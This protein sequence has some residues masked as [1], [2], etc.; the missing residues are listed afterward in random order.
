M[1]VVLSYLSENW[2]YLE[3]NR[4][5]QRNKL[6]SIVLTPRFRAS[7]HLIF[8][9]LSEKQRD[10]ILVA[11][12]PRI[13]GDNTR[14]LCEAEN[15]RQ[16]Q[17]MREGGFSSIPRLIA[18]D[19]WGG[20]RLLI[21]TALPGQP[22]KPAIVRE[23]RTDCINA[24]LSWLLKVQV[25]S[26]LSSREEP[27]WYT[28]LVEQPIK[29]LAS[30]FDV[31]SSEYQL[32]GNLRE[33]IHPLQHTE[34]PLVFEHGDLSSPNI[35][36]GRNSEI[37]VVDWELSDPRGYPS[38]DL[39]FFL[40]YVAFATTKARS[41]KDYVTAFDEAFF[42][43]EAWAV[44]YLYEYADA[45]NLP[46]EAIKPLFLLYWCRNLAKL[47][48]RLEYGDDRKSGLSS[49]TN[50]WLASNRFFALWKHAM[51]NSDKMVIGS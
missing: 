44:P 47:A 20:N 21:A 5:G 38:G 16:V 39:F 40:T 46:T 43:K 42:G 6:T 22:M 14:L 2:D 50:N 37:G 45:I 24:V 11:K 4:F 8:F 51:E 1:D 34:L 7:A 29:Y 35:L 28:R 10:P 25:A 41:L 15:L 32:L 30:V 48:G 31:S 36:M 13:A 27:N 12:V 26:R 19:D 18:S 33:L 3:L 17:S 49:E 9:I 23:H